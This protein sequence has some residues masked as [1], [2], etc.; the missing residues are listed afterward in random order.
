MASAK[1]A[2]EKKNDPATQDALRRAEDDF[3]IVFMLFLKYSNISEL[4]RM[5]RHNTTI[6]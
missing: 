1:K 2:L 6:P 3:G 4:K 5:P